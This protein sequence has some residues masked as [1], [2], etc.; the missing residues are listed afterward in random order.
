MT[1]TTVVNVRHERCDVKIGRN[2][3]GEVPNPPADG[4]FGNPFTVKEFGLERCLEFFQKY[5]KDRIEV[6][7]EFRAAVLALKG[8]K[9]GCF[10]RP[11]FGFNG[12]LQCHGQIIA[13][14]LDDIDPSRIS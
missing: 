14:W 8:K 13:G 9:L 6:D 7:L 10:C 11:M 12:K 4:C 1:Q 3:H 5:F 2:S